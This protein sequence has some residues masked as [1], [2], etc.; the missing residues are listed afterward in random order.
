LSEAGIAADVTDVA[1]VGLACRFAG[2]SN[3]E[4]YWD[5]ICEGEEQLTALSREQ[6]L[7]AGVPTELIDDPS[8]VPVTSLIEGATD[9]DAAFFGISP[10]EAEL[11]DPQHRLL[12]ELCWRALEDAGCDPSRYPGDIGVFAGGGRH[13]YLRNVDP[14]LDEIERLDGSIR[15]L[16]VELGN[17]GDFLATGCSFRMGL[18]GPSL[19]LQTAC[20]T[21]LVA[22]HLACQS[23]FL[24]ESD[25]VLAGGVNVHSPQ[26]IGYVYEEGSLCSPDGHLRPFDADA[27]G[28]LFGNGGGV[29][30]L[31]RLS[32][33]LEAGDQIRAV[34]KGTA[35]NNDGT[36][37]MTY[38]AP[39]VDGQAKVIARALRI[40]GVDP[41]SIGYI[42]AHGT[43]TPLGDP[44]EIAAL[45]EAFGQGD[46]A[47]PFCAIGAVKAQIGHLGAGAGVAGL[48]KAA[49][50][51]ER[52]WIPPCA[53][54]E[55]LN[56]NIALGGSPFYIPTEGRT[57]A[58]PRFAGVSA[59]GVGGTNAHAVLQ[60]PPAK[61]PAK[62]TPQPDA[63]IVLS[64]RSEK[65]LATMCA[66]LG[67]HLHKHPELDVGD[68]A[69]VLATGRKRFHHRISVA[70]A[71]T[72]EAAAR[73]AELDRHARPRP[74]SS[75]A[76]LPVVF[77][78]AGQGAHYV[79]M[80]RA[81]YENDE[82][83]RSTIDE[84]SSLLRSLGEIDVRE[85]LLAGADEEE[86]AGLLAR[87]D[88]VQPAV[89]SCGY[90]LARS[91]LE[92]G[93]APEALI[94]H[95]L[96]EYVAAC[97]A[98]V[99]TFEDALRLTALRGR[100]VQSTEPGA[101]TAVGLDEAELRKIVPA[102]LDLAA[103]NSPGQC[104]VSG[105]TPAI[106]AFEEQLEA[107]ETVHKRLGTPH[108]IHSSLM[109]PILDELRDA[110]G[111]V[112]LGASSMPIASSVTGA[113][114][115]PETMASPEYWVRHLRQPVRFMDGLSAL[116]ERGPAVLLEVGPG[117]GLAGMY[118][119]TGDEEIPAA[120]SPWVPG[121][122]AGSVGEIV[123]RLWECGAEIDWER[124]F[125][126][127]AR[128]HV[129]LPG[130]PFERTPFWV[131]RPPSRAAAAPTLAEAAASKASGWLRVPRW[132]PASIDAD[133]EG[134]RSARR[135][136]LA[137]VPR[138]DEG[139]ASELRARGSDV[140]AVSLDEGPDRLLARLAALVDPID[141]VLWALPAAKSELS[142]GTRVE[143]A[144]EKGFWPL[145]RIV[146]ELARRRGAE[147]LDVLVTSGG[148]RRFSSDADSQPELA[149]LDG[150]CKVIPQEYPNVR[151]A[152][153]DFEAG[154]GPDGATVAA[155]LDALQPGAVVAHR[156]GTRYLLR[157]EGAEP[158]AEEAPWKPS[159]SYLITGG[160]GAIGLALAE[161]AAATEGVTLT[162][163][164]RS[165]LPAASDWE[166]VAR[167]P[168]ADPD[169]RFALASLQRMRARGVEV[170]C[171]VADVTDAQDLQRLYSEHGPFDGIVHA[172]GVPS[173]KLIDAI[174]A[175]HV[176]RVFAPKVLG[177]VLLDELVADERTEWM[178]LCSSVSAVFG[179]VGHV[180]YCAANA[181]LDAFAAWRTAAG[182]ATIS[183]DFDTWSER[184]MAVK[185]ARRADDDRRRAVEHPLFDTELASDHGIEYRGRLRAGVDWIVDEHRL[186]GEP[187]LPGVAMI[188]L[189]RAAAARHLATERLEI[190]E[191]D[192]LQ[193]LRVPAGSEVELAVELAVD[194][195]SLVATISCLQPDGGRTQH[196]LG[197]VEPLAGEAAP[198]SFEPAAGDSGGAP[199]A[200]SSA[201]A[202]G[203]RWENV[204]H[205]ERR[206]PDELVVLCELDPSFHDDVEDFGLHPALLDT[207][208]GA[209]VSAVAEG[210]QLP[211]SYER[212]AVHGRMPARV[213]SRIVRS[214][215]ADDGSL[216]FDVRVQ[217]DDGNPVVEIDG[218]SLRT[219]DADRLGDA[220]GGQTGNRRLVCEER[221]DLG[222]LRF[223]ECERNA[224]GV[225]EVEVE[226]LASALNFKEVL[227]A[228]GMF[229]DDSA[230]SRLGLECAGV[231]RSVGA[232]VGHVAV[233]D[234]VMG[235]GRGC[236]SELAVLPGA[237][238]HRVP[239]GLTVE[240]AATIPVAFTTAYDCLV[241][242]AGLRRGERVLVQAAAGG[243]GLAALQIARHLGAEVFG[244]AG[245]ATKRSFVEEMG[246][247]LVMDS[248][249]TD[250]E[251]ETIEAGG[252]DV[253]LNS[254][255]GDHIPAGLRTLRPRGRF[256]E[257]GQRGILDG[258]ALDLGI[259]DGERTFSAY[260]PDILSD[261]FVGSLRTVVQLVE[262]GLLTPLPAR[263]FPPE[264]VDEAF[265][266]M[267]R[268]H[269]IGKVLVTRAGAGRQ[270]VSR[271]PDDAAQTGITAPIGV[272]AVRGALAM[273]EPQVLVTRRSLVAPAEELIVA[274][275]VLSGGGA[276]GKARPELAYECVPLEG[277]SERALG[278]IWS[279]L[280]GMEEV[281]AED[282]F[283]DLGGDSLGATQVVA[284]IRRAFGVRIAPADLLEDVTLRELAARLDELAAAADADLR[285]AAARGSE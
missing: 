214:R 245:N 73:L 269:H 153:V 247:S 97:V 83:F 68:V 207:A 134:A 108:A 103:V 200:K 105:P 270:A 152:E 131:P 47:E 158:V 140:L 178:L 139:V 40:S 101:M 184:G 7:A 285:V 255:S 71:G 260:N 257:I 147:P 151:I 42:E 128:R 62:P 77:A 17:Y 272:S 26:E 233:G 226:V 6:M 164:Q 89:F 110:V 175:E 162:L 127:R 148:R 261:V 284:R 57:W 113:W 216:R 248:R 229:G 132:V 276:P 135:R 168:A 109:D 82:V 264:E 266:F 274:E 64:A 273:G 242:V 30:A 63:P 161:D 84:A 271:R 234:L 58:A 210:V 55:N 3:A 241:N 176:E 122:E 280:L 80:G 192:L 195:P 267:S 119:Q 22:V 155:E 246:A 92:R 29:V 277:E 252:V 185:E 53:N 188:E 282:R 121:E 117:R 1:I 72:E 243:V 43:G 93:V 215:S 5:R 218:Y 51:L 2:A 75:D 163:A 41:G 268:A 180:D 145:L 115:E 10:S 112:E 35:I 129:S 98:G 32:D 66:E 34:I 44:I 179:G 209:L 86:A 107:A 208:A 114:V 99:F 169:L 265:T 235:I 202:L 12:L 116:R 186:A 227:I 143:E 150:P 240:Q 194:G 239:P 48:I 38:T 204:R 56:P 256:V 67:S 212:I 60:E 149:L 74:L 133:V 50:V 69:Y 19:N 15:G 27:K 65:A 170:E 46:V 31:K 165:E 81:L 141:T 237:L 232:G 222:S 213:H 104:V 85:A 79:G 96:G 52:G 54:F 199:V 126:G 61:P 130:Y 100:L 203:P 177:A 198:E 244:T 258:V 33:A 249:G 13:A 283:L 4:E 87:S 174:D 182:R 236:F 123:G 78:F 231:V 118:R 217:D 24:G 18:R 196:A 106:A 189:I 201:L 219:V 144:T 156:R 275:H 171:V 228:A 253:V 37:K 16:Q 120:V 90:A 197:R 159:G 263:A 181:F 154:T 223:V 137:V 136:V 14:S 187:L 166:K 20:S 172:A 190:T 39:S 167:D 125:R 11:M 76:E 91:L 183:L 111:S 94:G 88:W 138:D 254:I 225:E 8:F 59:F 279:S 262:E 45:T 124:H 221:G 251:R 173:G 102:G 224:P 9:F 281:G 211:M 220:V 230:A 49:L 95:S 193:P 206:G 21:S 205:Y 238:V 25:V 278:E 250:F 191:L 70:A 259:F 157:Y 142:L 160:L 23:L 146:P 28:T 36:A